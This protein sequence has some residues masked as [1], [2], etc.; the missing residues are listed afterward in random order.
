M[1]EIVKVRLYSDPQLTQLEREY[2]AGGTTS[3]QD[4]EL[5]E[6]NANTQYYAVGYATDS[7]GVTGYSLPYAF[8]TTAVTVTMSGDIDYTNTYSMLKFRCSV[9]DSG[10]YT[11]TQIGIEIANNAR[12]NNNPNGRDE[13]R[14]FYYNGDG[15]TYNNIQT[16]AENTTY[17]YRYFADFDELGRIYDQPQQNTITTMYAPP[18]FTILPFDIESTTAAI[19]ISYSGNY[20]ID[21]NTLR[22]VVSG[23]T[24]DYFDVNL[25]RLTASTPVTATFEGLT[26]GV[27]YECEVYMNYYNT[28]AE[29]Y[30]TFQTEA[31]ELHNF[32]F[33]VTVSNLTD[34]QARLL[35]TATERA[36]HRYTVTDIGIDISSEPDFSGHNFGG[37]KGSA[38]YTYTLDATQL[39]SNR[40][41]YYRPWIT[42]VEYGREYG[43]ASTFVTLYEMP[44]VTITQ[45]TVESHKVVVNVAY[46]GQYPV[47]S[48]GVVGISQNGVVIETQDASRIVRNSRNTFTFERLDASTNYVVF[49]SG[50]YYDDA[51]GI[52]A[53]LNVTTAARVAVTHT[54]SWAQNGQHTDVIVVT[55]YAPDEITYIDISHSSLS[56]IREIS[57]TVEGNTY[58]IVTT[59]YEYGTPVLLDVEIGLNNEVDTTVFTFN[60]VVPSQQMWIFRTDM[61]YKTG[62]GTPALCNTLRA[63]MDGAGYAYYDLD[64]AN[65]TATFTHTVTGDEYTFNLT[66]VTPQNG[67]TLFFY[68]DVIPEGTY[69]LS[70]TITNVFGETKTRTSSDKTQVGSKIVLVTRNTDKLYLN[71]GFN[72]Y[73]T[74]DYPTKRIVVLADGVTVTDTT[75]TPTYQAETQY[76]APAYAYSGFV[77]NNVISGATYTVRAYYDDSN[78][79]EYTYSEIGQQP[80][81]FKMPNGGNLTLTKVG[82][83][84]AV[85][86]QYS[87]N[88]G[89]WTTWTETNNVRTIAL[90]ANDVVYIRN[91]SSTTTQFSTAQNDYYIF[92]GDAATYGAG[93]IMSLLCSNP[94]TATM[95][96]WCFRRLFYNFANLLTAPDMPATTGANYCYYATLYGTGITESPEIMLEVVNTSACRSF[97]SN[98]SNLS[99][100]KVHF[101]NVSASY[102]ISNWLLDVAD[103]GTLYCPQSLV[104]TNGSNGLPNGWTRQDLE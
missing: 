17:Y 57:R 20:P 75:V 64:Y 4:V 34:S 99:L 31:Q 88:G 3:P 22:C 103:S 85:T 15:T 96:A 78:Y 60:I 1:I 52:T 62:A 5:L 7:N 55:T 68:F 43:E 74:N 86:L 63:N 97:M 61:D 19:T 24:G 81:N 30:T 27:V 90:T 51:D 21:Y 71:V 66:N 59:G 26:A 42:T 58:T 72:R 44:V 93:S 49:Y 69:T 70:L 102:A 39:N 67:H 87:L 94:A 23:A 32:D 54:D 79:A 83:P 35:T 18:V 53:T 91:A 6:L 12:F 40:I 89:Q 9:T 77:T 37:H 80:L 41:Y 101:T 104:L 73:Y 76:S 29:A 10:I 2:I 8:Q 56:E 98:C 95:S 38:G 36:G 25:D 45:S 28:T 50:A 92:S 33:V 48:N 47:P 11:P 84:A 65:T 82:N 14:V 100:V 13:S 16:F 46:S